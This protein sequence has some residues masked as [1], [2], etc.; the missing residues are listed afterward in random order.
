MGN[1]SEKQQTYQQ[2]LQNPNQIN[3]NSL[4]PYSVLNVP[5]N[6]TWEQLKDAYKEAALKTHPDKPGGSK[7]VF[8]FVTTCFKTLAE[9]YKA[10]K[11]YKSHHELREESMH[12]QTKP[13]PQFHETNEPFEKRFNRAFDECKYIDEETEYGYGKM[14]SKSSAIREDI[15][16][17]NMFQKNKIDNETFNQHFNKNVPVSTNIVKYKEPEPL[18]MAKNLQFTEIGGK[19]PDDYSGST[20]TKSLA[21]TDY[22]KAYSGTR[23]ANPEDI[24]SRKDFKSVE[25]YEKYRNKVIKKSLSEKER[26]IIDEQKALEEKRE[27]ERQERIKRQNLAIQAS[28]E[29]ANRLFLQ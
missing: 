21:Y 29:K 5:K 17:E 13:I 23:L 28:Y 11:S 12:A 27:Y 24:K 3:L 14:M 15:S 20:E 25:E 19:K 4:D 10:K 9:E 22:M 18:L 16:I 1:S 7:L 8:D 2:Y 6:F 26:K